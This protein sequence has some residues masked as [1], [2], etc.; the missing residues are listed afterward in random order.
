LCVIDADLQHPPEVIRE[1]IEQMPQ[2]DIAIASR[3]VR[4]GKVEGWSFSRRLVSK[5]AILLARPLVR[6][7]DPMSGCF[8]VKAE[9][10]KSIKFD[11]VGYKILLELLVKGGYKKVKEIPYS[12]QVRIHGESKLGFSEYL[13][14][15]K[16]LLRLYQYK[17]MAARGR[18]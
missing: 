2:Y 7:K 18:R 17:F 11:P 9:V 6:V 14:Y 13:K 4:S 3:Y 12:F 15:L 10:I 5:G 1:L 8:S 16:L